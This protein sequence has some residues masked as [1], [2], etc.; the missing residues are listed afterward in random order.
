MFFDPSLS[1][2]GRMPARPATTRA[3]VCVA[4]RPRRAAGRPALQTTG[5]ARGPVAPV[6]EYT[7][8][9]SDLLDN[10]ERM[11]PPGPAAGS[12]ATAAPT[13]SPIRREIPL[14]RR[15]RDG[16]SPTPRPSSPKSRSAPYARSIS[17]TRSGAA[18][19][20]DP[21]RAFRDA[22]ARAAGISTRGR[23]LSSLHAASTIGMRTMRWAVRFRRRNG[24]G[25]RLQR[26][27][28]G[29]LRGLPLQRRGTGRRGAGV[30]ELHLCRDRRAEKPG[31]SGQSRSGVFRSRAVRAGG[32][33]AAGERAVLRDVQDADIAERRG[34]PGLFPQRSD[35][36][37]ARR[38]SFLQHPRHRPG[39]WYPTVD[40][41][42]QKFNDLPPEYRQNL[43]RQAPLDGRRPGDPPAMTDRDLDDLEAFLE[44]LTDD[45]LVTTSSIARR[46]AAPLLLFR[47]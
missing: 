3:R 2:S 38:D 30:H 9:Y 35:Q 29:Q 20:A 28:E 27:G 24:E 34:A 6:R 14:P 23:Q 32:S 5:N 7:P 45:D 31:H 47:Q 22:P 16:Q 26:S 17:K 33:S 21:A 12:R 39:D 10:P 43:D 18:V 37:A 13:R 1:A 15:Q 46:P 25:C 11:I 44:T 41:V 40:G 8:P 19:F 4:E 42:V 36:V